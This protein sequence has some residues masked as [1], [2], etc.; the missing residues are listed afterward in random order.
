MNPT[1]AFDE[2][3]LSPTVDGSEILWD[4]GLRQLEGCGDMDGCARSATGTNTNNEFLFNFKKHFP[5]ESNTN[6]AWLTQF[7]PILC[8]DSQS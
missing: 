7:A 1:D 6:A 2:G 5:Y 4:G 3:D 8:K